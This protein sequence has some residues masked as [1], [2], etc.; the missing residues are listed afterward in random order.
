MG[1]ERIGGGEGGDRNLSR[2]VSK[3]PGGFLRPNSI[4]FPKVLKAFVNQI[5]EIR[6]YYS[7]L[8]FSCSDLP[9][10]DISHVTREMITGQYLPTQTVSSFKKPRDCIH[11]I[12][13]CDN[14]KPN[15]TDVMK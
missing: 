5:R 13:L 15:R 8:G 2:D 12:Y 6:A 4:V 9:H 1:K 10:A 14:E 7:F 3:I 11:I